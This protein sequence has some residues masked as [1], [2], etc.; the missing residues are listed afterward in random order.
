MNKFNQTFAVIDVG[1]HSILLLIGRRNLNGGF[2]VLQQQFATAKLGQNLKKTGQLSAESMQKAL[3]TFERMN[4]EIKKF[5]TDKVEVIGTAALRTAQNRADFM[6]QVY[7]RWGWQIK[8]LSAEEEAY[9]SYRGSIEAGPSEQENYLV[10]DVGGGSTEL[11]V[12]TAKRLEN[13]QSL[14][15]GSVSLAEQLNYKEHLCSS[16]R[17]G[18]MTLIKLKL[19]EVDFLTKRSP[20]R[21]LIGTG[22]T[23]STLAAIKLQ[24]LTYDSARINSVSLSRDELWKIYFRLNELALPERRKVMGMDPGREDVII[25]GLLIFL[26]FMEFEKIDLIQVSDKG[27]RFGYMKSLM[28][29][30]DN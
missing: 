18:L 7:E 29:V 3:E 30:R 15:L 20:D 10:M 23:I 28:E 14:D 9:Y 21:L 5:N 17:L 12:G 4:L 16:E 26:T 22:G 8:V 1:T 13:Q 25:Y 19:E 27:L 11:I 6:R 2:S 24:L